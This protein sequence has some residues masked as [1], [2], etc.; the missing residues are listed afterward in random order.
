L[1]KVNAMNFDTIR[2]CVLVAGLWSAFPQSVTEPL[3]F[4]GLLFA[5]LYF[6]EG[7]IPKEV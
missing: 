5:A 3:S 7:K 1:D 4:A 2:D 6:L